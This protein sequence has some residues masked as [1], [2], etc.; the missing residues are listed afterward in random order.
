MR[1][2]RGMFLLGVSAAAALALPGCCCLLCPGSTQ[3]TQTTRTDSLTPGPIT[4]RGLVKVMRT[5]SG[6]TTQFVAYQYQDESR[7]WIARMQGST[8][9]YDLPPGYYETLQGLTNPSGLY[10]VSDGETLCRYAKWADPANK[11][12][13]ITGLLPETVIDPEMPCPESP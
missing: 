13:T 6:G 5:T 7:I 8:I 11:P 3:S 12:Y 2:G 4:V 1:M 10:H 9:S